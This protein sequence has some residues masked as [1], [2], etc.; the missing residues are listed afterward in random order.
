MKVKGKSRC[1]TPLQKSPKCLSPLQ[2][3]LVSRHCLDFHSKDRLTHG[4]P[5]EDLWKSSWERLEG[6][7]QIPRSTWQEA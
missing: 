5:C 1:R 3:D 6:K 4:V 7:P 2:R